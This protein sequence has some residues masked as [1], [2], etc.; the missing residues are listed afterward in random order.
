MTLLKNLCYDKLVVKVDN[1]D[2]ID[3]VLKTKYQTDKTELEK[4][5]PDVTAFVKQVKLIELENKIPDIRNLATKTVLTAV[6]N[7][8]PHVSNLVKKTDIE[9]KLTDHTSQFNKLAAYVFNAR[10]AQAHL[11]T[12]TNFAA[13]LSRI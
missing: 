1:I 2:A 9:N 7:K 8:I 3:F 12:K 10:L 5:T 4:K 13:K 11:I 6:E